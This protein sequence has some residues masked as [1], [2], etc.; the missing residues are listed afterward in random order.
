[1]RSIKLSPAAESGL[2]KI[3]ARHVAWLKAKEDGMSYDEFA[4]NWEESNMD[5]VVK[6]E[7]G[8]RVTYSGFAGTVVKFCDWSASMYEVRLASGL[9]CVPAS[10]LV[11]P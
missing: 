7:A 2:K 6:F 10:D 11:K 5:N 8:D 1:M 4:R 9:V 3:E